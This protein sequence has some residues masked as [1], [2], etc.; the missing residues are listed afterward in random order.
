MAGSVLRS[1]NRSGP[2]VTVASLKMFKDED[3]KDLGVAKGAR[4]KIMSALNTR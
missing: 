2:Q 1:E 3:Y 4:L